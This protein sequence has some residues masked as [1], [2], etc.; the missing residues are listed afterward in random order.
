[1]V[2]EQKLIIDAQ[3]AQAILDYL[4]QRP[5]AEVYQLVA[6]LQRMEAVA[7]GDNP[8]GKKAAA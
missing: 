6:A 3:L 1:M 8:D 5:Y 2:M 7:E 4:V